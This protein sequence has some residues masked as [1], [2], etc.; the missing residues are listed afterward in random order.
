[1]RTHLGPRSATILTTAGAGGF[2]VGAAAPAVNML[3]EALDRPDT[4]ATPGGPQVSEAG[5]QFGRL[6]LWL[7]ESNPAPTPDPSPS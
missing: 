5:K 4:Y 1:M 6:R 2:T 7:R 3:E